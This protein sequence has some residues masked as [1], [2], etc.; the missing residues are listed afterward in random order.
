MAKS[1][2]R[3]SKTREIAFYRAV[4]VPRVGRIGFSEL[5][6]F[7]FA[8]DGESRLSDLGERNCKISPKGQS[9][10]TYRLAKP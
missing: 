7:V 6:K 1:D 3:A 8:H 10:T 4:P 2:E 9:A 5:G